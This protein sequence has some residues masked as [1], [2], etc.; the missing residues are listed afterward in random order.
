MMDEASRILCFFSF[1]FFLYLRIWSPISIYCM[2]DLFRALPFCPILNRLLSD[3]CA[4]EIEKVIRSIYFQEDQ[5]LYN[6]PAT[7]T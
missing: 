5:P 3:R 1:P 6:M 7:V 2:G 4:G